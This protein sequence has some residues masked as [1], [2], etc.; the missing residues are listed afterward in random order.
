MKGLVVDLG[1]IPK[2]VY[3]GGLKGPFDDIDAA[4]GLVPQLL[5]P[6]KYTGAWILN[7]CVLIWFK[8]KY[9]V[10]RYSILSKPIL[11]T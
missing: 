8:S 9:R 10:Y 5:P 4:I 6:G 11:Y 1:G 7:L 2:T 3:E